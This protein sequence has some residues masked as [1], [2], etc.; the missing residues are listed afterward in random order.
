MSLPLR[1]VLRLWRRRQRLEWFKSGQPQPEWVFPSSAATPLDDSKVWK[2]MLEIL[3]KA[4]VRRRPA[5]V[6]VLRH[7]FPSLL[8]QQGSH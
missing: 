5:I 4:E 2:A 8:I 3:K 1:A 7:T 6:H